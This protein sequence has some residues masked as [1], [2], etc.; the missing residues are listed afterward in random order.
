M[1]THRLPYAAGTNASPRCLDDVH[2]LS[3][4]V[5]T[6]GLAQAREQY[7]RRVF[8]GFAEEESNLSGTRCQDRLRINSWNR[9]SR[10]GTIFRGSMMPSGS[11][12][13]FLMTTET[14]GV[15]QRRTRICFFQRRTQHWHRQGQKTRLRARCSQTARG[16]WNEDSTAGID[17]LDGELF[18]NKLAPLFWT[19]FGSVR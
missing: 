1:G 3:A 18:R 14:E 10:S 8:F 17:L 13:A 12:L 4:D 7:R 6:V 15:D 9:G 5:R 2:V 19:E 11:S 16:W